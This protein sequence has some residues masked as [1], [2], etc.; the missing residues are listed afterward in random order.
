MI[1]VII[2]AYNSHAYIENAIHSII[3]QTIKEKINVYIVDDCSKKNYKEIID[4]YKNIIKIKE[5]KTKTNSGPGAAR[6]LG[7]DSSNSEYIIFIDADDE[8][9]NCF[10]IEKLYKTIVDNN[11]N[12]VSSYFTEEIDCDLYDHFDNT[13]WLHGKIYR[14]SFLEQNKIRFNNTRAN[15]DTGFNKLIYLLNDFY[16]ITDYTYIWRCNKQ[17][18]TRSTDYNFYG[19]EGF[20]YNVC[21]AIEEGIKRNASNE[22]IARICYETLLE[23]YYRYIY[24]IGR[25]ESK[26]IAQ[27]SKEL[28]KYYFNFNQYLGN[29]EKC[30]ILN[31]IVCKFINELGA[32]NFLNNTITFDNYLELI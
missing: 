23:M 2:P 15:E 25:E 31:E 17:S 3:M 4:K 5:I 18:L 29:I 28:K 30:E 27:W 9:D 26:L 10:S 13:I 1:D 6:Q 12:V 11:V 24:Y 19:L 21:W 7:V 14:R 22:R 8:F 20:A 32:N 16:F